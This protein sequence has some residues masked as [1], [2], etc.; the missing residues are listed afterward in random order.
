MAEAIDGAWLAK[1]GHF[2][3]GEVVEIRRAGSDLEVVIADEW[4]NERGLSMPDEEPAPVVLVFRGAII[5][6][7]AEAAAGGEISSLSSPEDGLYRIVFFDRDPV[8]IM[9]SAAFCR[10]DV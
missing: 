2:H 10:R 3:D 1:R 7:N 6:G 9:A 5:Q 8:T 4:V